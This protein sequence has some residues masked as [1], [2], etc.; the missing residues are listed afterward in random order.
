MQ[1]T[2]RPA[3]GG[4]GRD[5]RSAGGLRVGLAFGL[6]AALAAALASGIAG[7]RGAEADDRPPAQTAVRYADT[8]VH[9]DG[10]AGPLGGG[11]QDYE[12]AAAVALASMDELGVRLAVLLP[13]PFVPDHFNRYDYAPLAA[14]VRRHP[15]RF[16]FLGGGGSLNSLIQAAVRAGKTT[17]EVRREFEAKARE[18]LAAGAAG[19]G[20]IALEHLSF[21]PEHPYESAPP[22]HELLLLLADLAAAGDAVIDL[23]MEAVA[24]SKP[25]PGS[26]RSPPNPATLRENVAGLE[27]LLAH[28]GKARIVWAHAGWDNTGDWTVELSRRLLT[29]HANLCMSLKVD[30]LSLPAGRPL[31]D[32]GRLKAEWLRLFESFP[33]RF[34]LGSDQFYVAPG[35]PLRRPSSCRG[36]KTLLDQLPPE[37]ARKVGWENAARLYRLK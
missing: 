12:A 22:D 23:H 36:P 4:R 2:K 19:F 13:P 34:V 37:L 26:F 27:R 15:E 7:G 25:L 35:L 5:G 1:F 20:E 3:R 11:E 6:A 18:I 29:A 21:R 28:N 33:E 8:H 30:P 10:K 9:L 14:V 24:A 17:P 32:G 31:D 16:A